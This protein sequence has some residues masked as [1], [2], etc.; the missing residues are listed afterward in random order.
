MP[1]KYLKLLVLSFGIQKSFHIQ[2]IITANMFA[3]ISMFVDLPE[4]FGEQI[5]IDVQIFSNLSRVSNGTR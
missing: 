4:F 2:P 5:L 1:K 3:I